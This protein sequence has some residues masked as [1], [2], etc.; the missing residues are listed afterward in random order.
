M[1]KV[2]I[3]LNET[4]TNKKSSERIGAFNI[5][6]FK[7]YFLNFLYLF[8]NLSTRPAVSTKVILPV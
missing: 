2:Y 7:N 3:D 1:C 4:A 8:M 6:K 5:V